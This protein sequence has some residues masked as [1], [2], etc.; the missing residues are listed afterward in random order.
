VIRFGGSPSWDRSLVWACTY[1]GAF[2][3]TTS[4]RRALRSSDQDGFGKLKL[5]Q[6]ETESPRHRKAL[7]T[8]PRTLCCITLSSSLSLP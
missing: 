7:R 6:G 3:R 2:R 4:T 1:P 8:T 5:M